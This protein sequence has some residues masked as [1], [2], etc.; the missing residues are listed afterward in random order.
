M[1]DVRRSENRL[2]MAQRYMVDMRRLCAECATLWTLCDLR[3]KIF[4]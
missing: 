4:V 1:V 2:K 3:P